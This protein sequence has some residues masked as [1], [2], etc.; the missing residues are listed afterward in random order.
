M[1]LRMT[2]DEEKGY[3]VCVDPPL[4]TSI[5]FAKTLGSLETI[6]KSTAIE[7]IQQLF[8]GSLSNRM[9]CL[10][11]NGPFLAR[12]LGEFLKRIG[13]WNDF[14]VPP[15]KYKGDYFVVVGRSEFHQQYLQQ[16]V[17]STNP[18]EF[19]AQEDFLN[20]LLC[21]RQAVYFRDDPRIEE[22]PGL[23]YLATIGFRWPSTYATPGN[24]D[25][26]GTEDWDGES[27][28]KKKYGYNVKKGTSATYR[29]SALKK[30]IEEKVEFKNIVDHIAAMIRLHK[31]R[32][33]KKMEG[34]IDRWSEDLKWLKEVYYD[35]SSYRFVWPYTDGN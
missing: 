10:T 25:L 26:N 11:G 17:V 23:A 24:Y 14:A 22:H 9:V 7:V 21:G 20:L 32:R 30:A 15:A 4:N 18:P 16:I 5:I 12:D 3:S 27:I 1:G 6:I 31:R 33:D 34:A 8:K 13:A 35:N 28:L 19:L 2:D 29:R